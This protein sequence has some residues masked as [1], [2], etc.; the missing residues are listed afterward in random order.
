MPPAAYTTI[1]GIAGGMLL[2]FANTESA[3]FLR[4]VVLSAIGA[5]SSFLVT[6]FLSW[7]IRKFRRKVE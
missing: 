4:T 1:T 5:T 2:T 7:L 3:D 6:A